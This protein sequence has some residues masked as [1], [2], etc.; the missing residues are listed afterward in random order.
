MTGAFG[1]CVTHQEGKLVRLA[2]R[3][4]ASVGKEGSRAGTVPSVRFEQRSEDWVSPP[5]GE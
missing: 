2:C 1:R 4:T 5:A 3:D